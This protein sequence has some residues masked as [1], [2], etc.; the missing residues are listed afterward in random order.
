[1]RSCSSAAMQR[2]MLYMSFT[3]T[4]ETSTHVSLGQEQLGAT[5]QELQ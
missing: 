3:L 1:M 4:H 2:Y 5:Y